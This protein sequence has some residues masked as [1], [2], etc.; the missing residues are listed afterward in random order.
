MKPTITS[1]Q[2]IFFTKELI[3]LINKIDVK[4]VKN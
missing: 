2:Q 4:K 3:K 1:S